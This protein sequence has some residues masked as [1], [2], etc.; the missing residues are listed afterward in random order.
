MRQDKMRMAQALVHRPEMVM[1][2]ISVSA[3]DA[4]GPVV[5]QRKYSVSAGDAKGYIFNLDKK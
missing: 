4:K 3:T 5:C 1:G 2:K